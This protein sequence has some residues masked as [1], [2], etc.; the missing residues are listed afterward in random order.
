M[1]ADGASAL[2]IL[3]RARLDDSR[4]RTPVRYMRKHPGLQ[5]YTKEIMSLNETL[6]Y[7]MMSAG[8]L[9]HPISVTRNF[10]LLSPF[11]V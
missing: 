10:I 4:A 6:K 5:S 3:P 8:P 9:C 1:V 11:S 2:P 7:G